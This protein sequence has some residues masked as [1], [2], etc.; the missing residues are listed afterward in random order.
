[1]RAH[2]LLAVIFQIVCLCPTIGGS[3]IDVASDVAA[4][5]PAIGPTVIASIIPANVPSTHASSVTILGSSFETVSTTGVD[6]G[7]DWS[8]GQDPTPLAWL[9][10][11]STRCVPC[12]HY[13]A[14]GTH[15]R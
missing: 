6:T 15:H 13:L 3:L 4:I 5:T 12:V 2:L 11:Q 9:G 1:M 7:V 8:S 10:G 14:A